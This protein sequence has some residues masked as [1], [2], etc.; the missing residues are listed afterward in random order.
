[1]PYWKHYKFNAVVPPTT[2]AAAAFL[3]AGP[4]NFK[5]ISGYQRHMIA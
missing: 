3:V 2:Q 1:M 4:K 5:S